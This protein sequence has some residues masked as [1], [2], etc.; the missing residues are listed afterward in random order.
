V[1]PDETLLLHLTNATNAIITRVDGIGTILSDDAHQPPVVL[2]PI[3]DQA[4]IYG[5]PFLFTFASNTFGAG[6]AG[7]VLLYDCTNLP[8]GIALNNLT[9]TFS[10]TFSNAGTYSLTVTV[11]D[12]LEPSFGTNDTFT[13]VVERA[14]LTVAADDK[15]REYGIAN[16]SLT[17]MLFGVTNGDNITAS[18]TC[19]ATPA[20]APG[21][22][23]IVP[24]LADPNNRLSNYVVT[25]S[26][27]M[28]SV[29]CSTNTSPVYQELHA[30]TT[31]SDGHNPRS[32]VILGSDGV[33]Y[34]TTVYG[35]AVDL[36]A[37]TVFSVNTDGSGYRKLHS[38]GFTDGSVIR[39]G[40]LEGSDG[41]LY[42]TASETSGYTGGA[43]FRLNKDGTG[44]TV[45]H[46]F[47]TADGIELYGTLIRGSDG[48]LYGTANNGGAH[49]NGCIFRIAENG[50]GFSVIY[51]FPVS[52]ASAARPDDGVIQ[53]SDGMLYG[54]TPFG[55][56]NQVGT[57]L[58]PERQRNW[59]HHIETF[60]RWNQRTIH[61]ARCSG[62]GHGRR[63]L[64]HD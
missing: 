40:L 8:P 55:G 34:G 36:Y 3:P 4:N 46:D 53:A 50:S 45:L 41:R 20:S 28:L 24:Q 58:P 19:A 59:L 17:G 13:V 38:F 56:S 48:L 2:N 35:G 49:F 9:R 64:R 21:N 23:P 12:N 39:S 16:P 51:N 18:F 22:Y 47:S 7:L 27:G 32:G 11:R 29:T 43:L 60:H 1:E 63:A 42:G 6:N 52:P 31:G 33:L 30:F 5:G 14:T 15:S 54:V 44:F 57:I 37:G 62:G 26:N 10:G 25:A 61:S